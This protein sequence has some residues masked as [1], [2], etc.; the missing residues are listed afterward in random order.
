[1]ILSCSSKETPPIRQR[2]VELVID[3]V[4]RKTVL[5]L[6]CELTRR[7]EDQRARHARPRAALLEQREHRQHEGG[8]L[9]GAG[10]REAE[11]IAA[12]QHV[13]DRLFLDRGGGGVADGLYGR[14][15][16]VA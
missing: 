6:R 13:R 15:D 4:A 1:M 3:A 2:E 9:A 11:H 5:H 8:R 10:L 16:L 14:D 7:L 12:R